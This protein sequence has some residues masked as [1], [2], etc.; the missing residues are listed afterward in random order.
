MAANQRTLTLQEFEKI[1]TGTNEGLLFRG[2]NH[3]Y[4]NLLP[5]IYRKLWQLREFL[6]DT[7]ACFQQMECKGT[8]VVSSKETA[9][10]LVTYRVRMERLAEFDF[11]FVRL[12]Q[13]FFPQDLS[14]I[15]SRFGKEVSAYFTASLQH[16]EHK[17]PM[18]DFSWSPLIAAWFACFDWE[19]KE[20]LRTNPEAMPVI[21][22]LNPSASESQ[23]K[24]DRIYDLQELPDFI[25]RPHRQQGAVIH[26][27]FMGDIYPEV[28]KLQIDPTNAKSFFEERGLSYSY[29]FPDSQ[30]ALFEF[31]NYWL[32]HGYEFPHILHWIEEHP[33]SHLYRLYRDQRKN[34][35]VNL[36]KKYDAFGVRN[37][38]GEQILV[39]YEAFDHLKF[40][41]YRVNRFLEILK[42][43][44][45]FRK[46]KPTTELIEEI[47]NA[48]GD[49]YGVNWILRDGFPAVNYGEPTSH[50]FAAESDHLRATI[51]RAVLKQK[52]Q[53]VID[54]NAV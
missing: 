52:D 31:N 51:K 12:F 19:N 21:Y 16:I 23:S 30:D 34:V 40:S 20:Y 32:E 9:E 7:N 50:P 28:D 53:Y 3:D 45:L 47:I 14:S 4:G 10:E 46:S 26:C 24:S 33:E 54:W 49:P 38:Q 2:Q 18:L 1:Y 35:I 8:T 22:V 5:N 25:V 27:S 39:D 17:T 36:C 48:G 29:L 42:Q 43:T 44:H 15:R 11:P 6:P 13:I 41:T 37:Q